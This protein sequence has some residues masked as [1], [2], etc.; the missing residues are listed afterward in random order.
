M[1]K[2]IDIGEMFF[3]PSPEKKVMPYKHSLLNM[4]NDLNYRA[5]K[6]AEESLG[7]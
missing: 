4:A 7:K 2:K 6:I 1:N 5:K 3:Y